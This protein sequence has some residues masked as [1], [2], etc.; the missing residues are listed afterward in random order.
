MFGHSV[1]ALQLGAR[2]AGAES[3]RYVTPQ[4]FE[5]ASA[6]EVLA[7]DAGR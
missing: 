2:A 5:L 4:D 1:P 7:L 6:F 3:H